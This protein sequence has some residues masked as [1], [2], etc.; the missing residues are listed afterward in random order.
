MLLFFSIFLSNSSTIALPTTTPS[1]YFET[2]FALSGVLI[3]KPTTIG[4]FVCF[5]SLL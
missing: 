1:A 5:F 2:I 4:I 3:P